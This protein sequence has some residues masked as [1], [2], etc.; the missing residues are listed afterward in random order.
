[1]GARR[2]ARTLRIPFKT[3]QA[4]IDQYF[5]RYGSIKTYMDGTLAGAQERGYV[6]TLFGR[7]RYVPDLGSKSPQLASAAERIAINTPIQ[8]TAADL[9]KV[10][11][12]TIARQLD[13]QGLRA[14]M[15][16]QVHD[17]LLF[18][19]PDSELEQIRALV[20]ES[21]EG[22]MALN[23]PLRVDVGVGGNWAEAH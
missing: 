9:I 6:S 16:L 8:G 19:V 17:E 3:A 11:M 5:S 20:R 7:R 18:E 23:V 10:A 22:V 2:L 4:Y 15:L 14:R 21:M 12:V 13:R 1:M